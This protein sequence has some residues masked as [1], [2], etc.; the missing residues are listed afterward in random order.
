MSG[1]EC[2]SVT[3]RTYKVYDMAWL[4]PPRNATPLVCMGWVWKVVCWIS[5]ASFFSSAD[6]FFH[7]PFP[8]TIMHNHWSF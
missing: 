8:P 6:Y 5:R 2:E 1:N 3:A 4:G 7:L